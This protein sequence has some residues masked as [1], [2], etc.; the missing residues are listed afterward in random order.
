MKTRKHVRNRI[1]KT[2]GKKATKKIVVRNLLR[3][4]NGH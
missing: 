3:G 1:S 4:K 2:R